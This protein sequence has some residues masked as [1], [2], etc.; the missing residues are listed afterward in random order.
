MIRKEYSPEASSDDDASSAPS[1]V[2]SFEPA[3]PSV[4]VET[5]R[6]FVA[7]GDGLAFER[8]VR[9]HERLVMGVCVRILGQRQAAEDAFQETF[10]ALA[11][12]AGTIR[13]AGSLP[14]WLHRVASNEALR[15]RLQA[16]RRAAREAAVERESVIPAPVPEDRQV[17]A[18]IDEALGELPDKYRMPLVLR[19]VEGLSTETAARQ[20]GRHPNSDGC[21]DSRPACRRCLYPSDERRNRDRSG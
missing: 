3:A 13:D 10:I 18:L 2:P 15:I 12:R 9:R 19:Y 5:F 6:N 1:D 11:K 8:I 14:G 20:L 21:A 17:F 4:D 7:S 16:Q